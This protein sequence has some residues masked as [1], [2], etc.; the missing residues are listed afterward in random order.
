MTSIWRG[1]AIAALALLAGTLAG[2][3]GPRLT[4]PA[5]PDQGLVS[6]G[7]D[8]RTLSE[9]AH[10]IVTGQVVRQESVLQTTSLGDRIVTTVELKV[11]ENL[12]GNSP[13]TVVVQHLGGRV[14]DLVMW[15]SHEPRFR[16]GENVVL[17]LSPAEDGPLAVC[18]GFRGKLTVM[19]NRVAELG[20]SLADFAHRVSLA[21]SGRDPGADPAFVPLEEG[22]LSL[23]GEPLA[24]RYE[25]IRWPQVQPV[26]PYRINGQAS[27]L[28]PIQAASGTWNSVGSKLSFQ[29]AG[30][31]T[32]PAGFRDGLNVIEAIRSYGATGWP[33]Q[34]TVWY[35]TTSTGGDILEC[36]I[37][38]NLYYRWATNGTS[39]ALDIQSLVTHELGHWLMLRDLYRTQEAEMTMYGLVANG[40]TKKRTL[41][42]PDK[43]GMLD[44]Y[45]PR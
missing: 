25:E 18:G 15:V 42:E 12:K 11:S 8:T 36:D 19:G 22:S 14:G 6:F 35:R 1:L 33:A 34:A 2:C 27:W 17:F 41:E 20:L 40:E 32:T 38:L 45:G 29:Y 31:T 5:Q 43:R 21:L 28:G 24:Y 23:M 16:V 7:W 10:F 4:A 13:E 44:I 30:T 3:L 37:A 39:T 9:A 26:V